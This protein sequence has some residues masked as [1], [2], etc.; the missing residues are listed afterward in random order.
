MLECDIEAEFA[1]LVDDQQAES[2][3]FGGKVQVESL[4]GM[5]VVS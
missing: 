5:K 4:V 3:D 2:E 1:D